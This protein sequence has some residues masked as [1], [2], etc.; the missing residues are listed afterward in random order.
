MRWL[1]AVTLQALLA[2]PPGILE[3]AP[4]AR[5]VSIASAT[6]AR[7]LTTVLLTKACDSRDEPV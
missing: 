6:L 2:Q 7:G 5:D 1:L 4:K 3:F